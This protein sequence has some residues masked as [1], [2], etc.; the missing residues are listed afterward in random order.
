MASATASAQ[1]ARQSPSP[2]TE[3]P[4]A[5]SVEIVAWERFLDGQPQLRQLDVRLSHMLGQE[6]ETLSMEQITQLQEV[7]RECL[8][9]LEEGR[10][11]LAR[12]LERE[13]VETRILLELEKQQQGR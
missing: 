11:Q 3:L 10:L 7:Q 4:A 2:P 8:L 6:I 1:R 13:V 12:R 5:A 9:Q